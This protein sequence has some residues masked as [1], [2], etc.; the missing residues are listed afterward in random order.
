MKCKFIEAKFLRELKGRFLCEIDI[1]GNIEL[2]HVPNSAKLSKYIEIE[3]KN[4]LVVKNENPKAKTRYQLCAVETDDNHWI[5]VNL[6]LLN[7]IIAEYYEDNG[8]NVQKERILSDTYKSDLL[9]K[10]KNGEQIVCEVK[11]IIANTKDVIFPMYSGER[12]VRQLEYFRR[13]LKTQR[14]SVKY[15]FVLLDNNIEVIYADKLNKE[16]VKHMRYCI[17][18]QMQIEF[19]EVEIQDD[20]ISAKKTVE[21][22]FII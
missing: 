18:K 10:D 2:A 14:F 17:K 5:M 15:V 1:D 11:G 9:I 16:F 3:D 7:K 8:C 4:V 6:N 22:K 20:S 13:L 19:F 21:K 12:T